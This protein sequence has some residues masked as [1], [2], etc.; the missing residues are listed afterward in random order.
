M[1]NASDQIAVKSN[2]KPVSHPSEFG[3]DELEKGMQPGRARDVAWIGS[4]AL[5]ILLVFNSGG[6]VKW[7]QTLPST[8]TNAS[9]A[10][11]AQSWHQLM[12]KIGSAELFEQAR[13]RFK[14]E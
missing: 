12:L 6:L 13:E 4:I 7:T 14:I 11:T 5:A 8:A 1:S 9:I 2:D 10:E 3:V